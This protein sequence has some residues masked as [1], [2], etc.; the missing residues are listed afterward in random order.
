MKKWLF[1]PGTKDG[2]RSRGDRGDVVQVEVGR[3]ADRPCVRAAIVAAAVVAAAAAPGAASPDWS[4]FR[5]PNGSGVS[6]ATGVPTEFGPAR[7]LCGGCPCRRDIRRRS[8]STI[9]FP[10]RL[11]RAAW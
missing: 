4:R 6:S 10:H 5:G 2:K 1:K 7:N 8:C 11:S 3:D 9:G